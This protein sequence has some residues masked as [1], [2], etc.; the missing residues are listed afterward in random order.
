[1]R[2]RFPARWLPA[3]FF[4]LFLLQTAAAGAADSRWRLDTALGSPDWLSLDGTYRV[5]Y[6]SL[7]GDYRANAPAGRDDILVERL[8]VNARVGGSRFYADVELEDSRQQ[9]ADAATPVGTD[10]VNTVEPLQAFLGARFDDVFRQGDRLDLSAGRITIDAGSRRLVA[11]NRFRN[12]LNAFTGIEGVWTGADGSRVQT[13]YT[14][15]VQREPTAKSA[16]LD[17]DIELDSESASIRF[18]GLIASRPHV[19]GRATGEVY[20]YGL[21]SQ[22]A[23]GIAV[24]DRNL[25]TPG[26]R[27]YIK[28]SRH[29]WDFELEGALQFGISRMTTAASDRRD[30]HHFAQ[31]FHGDMG[32]T[33]AAPWSP[34]VV[35][36]YDYASGDRN[37]RDGD[38]N[39]FD[40]LY[41]ARR[42]DFGPTGIYG[43][44]ARSNISTPGLRIE[45]EPT[46]RVSGMFGYRAFWLASS[47][48]QFTT[49][50]L[51]DPTG[52]S[53]S[54]LGNQVETSVKV[55]L[56]PSNLALEIGA[57]YLF[58]GSFLETV[59][60]APTDDDTA[61]FYTAATLTF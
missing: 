40:T 22:D 15:P 18:W 1:M 26:A 57:A 29:A 32:Y 31:F 6:E 30:L 58:H 55:S 4:G 56:L 37:P 41:G 52:G 34:R 20:L 2:C 23:P 54:F 10:I 33:F 59:P 36:Q 8:L 51:Q 24:A 48:D 47:R 43:A 45:V 7:D 11:R 9:L 17:N 39:R 13:F 49:A 50:K 38:D 35:L 3:A 46:R 42:F 19:L 60:Q 5:R 53:G 61:Y 44:F 14:L 16:L 25:Y 28:P 21:H 27:M 12:T